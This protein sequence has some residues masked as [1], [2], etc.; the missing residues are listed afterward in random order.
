MILISW[1]I[2]KRWKEWNF[3]VW[4]PLQLHCTF[5]HWVLEISSSLWFYDFKKKLWKILLSIVLR[6]GLKFS[7]YGNLE[8]RSQFF[9]KIIEADF[10]SWENLGA[11]FSVQFSPNA[12]HDN[13]QSENR[14]ETWDETLNPKP[15]TGLHFE[16]KLSK[17]KCNNNN[18]KLHLELGE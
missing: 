5:F 6:T 17:K 14:I 15:N 4:V 1:M 16:C 2:K 3:K 13:S 11:W 7:P 12:I 10:Y 9:L 8:P 18:K